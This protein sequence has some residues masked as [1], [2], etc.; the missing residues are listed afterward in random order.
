[1]DIDYDHLWELDDAANRD[2]M[3][4]VPTSRQHNEEVWAIVKG[5]FRPQNPIE[6]RYYM[7]SRCKDL[8][9]TGIPGRYLLSNRVVEALHNGKFTG[10][11]TYPVAITN[12]TG[13]PILGYHGFSI[14]GRCG[15]RD[16][17]RSE[18]VRKQYRGGVSWELKGLYFDEK[19]WDGSDIFMPQG[20]AYICMR[21]AV[22]DAIAALKP[23]NIKFRRLTEITAPLIDK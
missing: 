9:A 4:V 20:T 23:E 11:T 6:Y 13:G 15:P 5:E 8:M 10:W 7:R 12:K 18:K 16:A 19:S 3:I 2:S 17:S 21:E 22:H 1:M 14:T